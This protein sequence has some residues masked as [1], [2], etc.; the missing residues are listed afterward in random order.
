MSTSTDTAK[1]IPLPTF[2]GENKNFQAWWTRFKAYAAV[3][4]FAQAIGTTAD[5]NLPGKE[6]EDLSALNAAEKVKKNV[7]LERNAVAVASLTMA[8]KSDGLLHLVQKSEDTDW[9]NGV[10]HKVVDLLF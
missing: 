2:D 8:F 9:P 10:A 4:K 6:E 7:A 5:P 3:K 1:G